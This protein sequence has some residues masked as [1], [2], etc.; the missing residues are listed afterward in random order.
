[1][2]TEFPDEL[3]LAI[4]KHVDWI[5]LRN[6]RLTCKSFLYLTKDKSL[7]QYFLQS[8]LLDEAIPVP[9]LPG[10]EPLARLP[11]E[12]LES[13]VV[14]ALTLRRNWC[15]SSP[16][17]LWTAGLQ[18]VENSRVVRLHFPHPEHHRRW[19]LSLSVRIG[20]GHRFWLQLW[21]LA[22]HP[23]TCMAQHDWP[24]VTSLVF[25][26][27]ED[28]VGVVAVHSDSTLAIFALEPSPS[29]T[30]SFSATVTLPI[31]PTSQL[32][33]FSGNKILSSDVHER[34]YLWDVTAPEVA[35]QLRNV[36]AGEVESCSLL[37]DTCPN[38]FGQD[39]AVLG[40][41][42][43]PDCVV[44][45]RPRTIELYPL[46]RTWP[47]ESTVVDPI[48]QHQYQWRMD[49]ITLTR[50]RAS[51]VAPLASGQRVAIG[52]LIRFGSIFPWP[53]NMLHQIALRPNPTFER[54]RGVTRVNLP[55]I[56]PPI[57]QQ[58]LGAPVRLFS[59]TDMVL[60]PYGTAMWIDNHTE[61]EFGQAEQGQRL[62]SRVTQPLHEDEAEELELTDQESSTT[63]AGSVL[64]YN[65]DVTWG[66]VAIDEEEGIVAVGGI[67]GRIS[68][69]GYV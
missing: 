62:A 43:E 40:A 8:R 3:Y 28:G 16:S 55:Y 19:L 59:P 38:I 20:G 61:D 56:F 47:Q 66:K 29:G 46:P 39:Q 21:D 45:V 49:S 48:E 7:W 53:V 1:M 17:A 32:H 50:F 14:N 65:E 36:E 9:G 41:V 69:L 68:V 25:N 15:S 4:F 10:H 26:E 6:I 5:S 27:A 54:E 30:W 22:A 51:K 42:L 52:I 60:G 67:D 44:V 64:L 23:A 34:V 2:A 57:A 11:A 18:T 58:T 35:L 33:L 31:Q 12:H 13:C 37:C 24:R 63:K